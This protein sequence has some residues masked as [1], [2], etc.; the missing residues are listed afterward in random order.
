[1]LQPLCILWGCCLCGTPYIDVRTGITGNGQES[2]TLLV[3]RKCLQAL[4]HRG[5]VQIFRAVIGCQGQNIQAAARQEKI[6]F[7]VQVDDLISQLK[8]LCVRQRGRLMRP[9]MGHT[10]MDIPYGRVFLQYAFISLPAF[11]QI[12]FLSA[13]RYGLVL[14]FFRNLDAEPS[15]GLYGC[16]VYFRPWRSRQGKTGGKRKGD[17]QSVI[18]PFSGLVRGRD[19]WC[20]RRLMCGGLCRPCRHNGDTEAQGHH[21]EP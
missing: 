1:M 14:F 4:L 17:S 3:G 11:L 5:K 10:R 6:A 2:R 16:Q 19:S 7:G 9:D 15:F 21:P 20:S 8:A 18:V 13:W 12:G